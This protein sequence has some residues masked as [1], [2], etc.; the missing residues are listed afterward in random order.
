MQDANSNKKQEKDLK[1]MLKGIPFIYGIGKTVLWPKRYLAKKK[2]VREEK[3]HRFDD[4]IN[5]IKKNKGEVIV[6]AHGAW[7]GVHAATD[8]LFDEVANLPEVES[9]DDIS[10]VVE[11]VVDNE[12]I[13]KVFFAAFAPGWETV[14]YALRKQKPELV[15]KV[16]WHGSNA[17]HYEVFDWGRF[18]CMF[19]MLEDGVIDS[20]V[21]VKK[22]MYE[23]YKKLGYKVEFLGNTVH[24]DGDKPKRTR[25]DK[26]I[27]IGMYASSDR[28]LKN[29]Y[30]QM[31]AVSLVEGAELDVIPLTDTALKYAKLLKLKVYGTERDLKRGELFK[32]I[33]EDD[34]VLYASF[35]EC[36]PMLPLECLEL[37]VPCITGNNHHYWVDTPLADYL[38][39][40]KV[41]DPVALAARIEK[42]LANK[43]KILKLY[44][45][46]KKDYDKECE[47]LKRK[48]CE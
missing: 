30:N 42:C 1:Q 15:M 3:K 2:Q 37:G 23:Q 22:S 48:V 5:S 19:K 31:A 11:A 43:D 39:E 34:V 45:E 4:V 44:R 26:R 36:A 41:D 10:G 18:E 17:M 14:A 28:W 13:K 24:I 38:I 16:I 27:R 25:K 32:R 6:F 9:D 21:F 46:W 33:V 29:F 12:R 8:E 35:V 40:P 7:I 20:I 47:A